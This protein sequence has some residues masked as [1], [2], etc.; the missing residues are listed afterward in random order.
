MNQQTLIIVIIAIVVIF[1]LLNRKNQEAEYFQLSY[2]SCGQLKNTGRCQYG[3]NY[4][5]IIC[6]G[7]CS[8]VEPPTPTYASPDSSG[9]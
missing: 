2:E 8:V 1:F 5:N 4:M 9:N 3:N 6:P 7:T